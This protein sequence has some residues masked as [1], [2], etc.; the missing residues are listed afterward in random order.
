MFRK[1]TFITAFIIA[2]AA[3]ATA[4]ATPPDVFTADLVMLGSSAETAAFLV[5]TGFNLGSHYLWETRWFLLSMDLGDLSFQWEPM[6]SALYAAEEYG[7]CSYSPASGAPSIP[8]FLQGLDAELPCRFSGYPFY[9]TRESDFSYFLRDSALWAEL[10]GKVHA[11]G[12]ARCFD[13]VYLAMLGRDSE[14]CYPCCDGHPVYEI[15]D[16]GSITRFYGMETDS[17][18]LEPRSRAAIGD[19]YILVVSVPDDL[20]PFDVI[21]VIPIS[22]MDEARDAIVDMNYE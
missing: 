11:F 13:P 2:H 4:A 22:E 19:K 3:A 17:I 7:G 20:A 18:P 21:F 12:S 14:Q 1:R 5:S 16:F 9:P 6:G 10:D 15:E 8:Q